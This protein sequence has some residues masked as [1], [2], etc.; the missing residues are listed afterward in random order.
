MSEASP[1]GVGGT[2]SWNRYAGARCDIE[3]MAYSYSFSPELEA[4]WEW[5][6]RYASQPEIL[7]YLEHVADRFDPRPDIELATRVQSCVLDEATGRWVLRTDRGHEVTARFCV[8]A[9]GCLSVENVPDIAGLDTFAGERYHTGTWPKEGVDFSGKR[10]GFIGTGSSGIQAIA[11]LTEAA[12]HLYVFQRTP[13][14]SM[15]AR[16]FAMSPRHQ[17]RVKE[18]DAA[19][20]ARF[21]GGSFGLEMPD[22]DLRLSEVTEEERPGP[23]GSIAF[24]VG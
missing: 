7:R 23:L 1:D 8:M 10:V 5:T 24:S 20:R 17:A 3:T 13:E 21:T 15:P 22:D 12:E 18:D 16:N 14:F 11:L 9:T 19:F 2:W 4:E 6:E